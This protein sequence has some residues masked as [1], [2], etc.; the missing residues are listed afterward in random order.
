MTSVLTI[1]TSGATPF[2]EDAFTVRAGRTA[3]DF[4][5]GEGVLTIADTTPPEVTV[6]GEDPATVE[7]S[8]GYSDPGATA[9]DACA[10]D[11]T[12]SIVVTGSVDAGTPGSYEL[13]YEATDA[14]GNTGSAVR[15]VEVV[16]T[17][18]PEV[19]CPLSTSAIADDNCQAPIPDVLTG[20]TAEDECSSFDSLTLSQDPPTGTPVDLGSH[21]ITVTVTDA[22]GNSSTCT[23]GFTVLNPAPVATITG[24]PSG[25]IYPVN[26]PVPLTGSFTDNAGSHVAIWKL[27]MTTISGTVTEANGSG[28]ISDNHTFTEAGVYKIEL[29]VTDGCSPAG[30]DTV[31]TVNDLDD[32]YVVIYDPD[33]GFVTG[34]GW[35]Q[36]PP[37]AY[38]RNPS[39]VGKANFGFVSK[40]K[41]GAT[42]PTG[43]TEFQFRVAGMNF[44]S[45]EYQ[46][47]VVSGSK[48]QYKG[49]GSIN[50]LGSFGFM[51][52]AIDGDL[53][54]SGDSDRFRMKIW[55]QN[56][57]DLVYDNQNG[58]A[59]DSE[60]TTNLEGGSIVIHTGGNKKTTPGDVALEMVPLGAP[61]KVYALHQN[62]PNPF[63]FS[64]Q[65][66]FDLPERSNVTVRVYDIRGRLVSSLIDGEREAGSYQAEWNGRGSQGESLASGV[67]L[68]QFRAISLESHKAQNDTKRMIYLK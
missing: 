54:Q 16:D 45:N 36:S 55:D 1:S 5:T 53:S 24:P 18:P 63:A 40:Y 37:G 9:W 49:I 19:S 31:D 65:V 42:K 35:I 26:T 41:K 12:G 25:S 4:A 28:T 27:D 44:H 2:G 64:T 14:E 43:E 51:L 50:G 7:C 17:T 38:P 56:T 10:G 58:V 21:T 46:W 29:I 59:D 48:A 20:T 62:Y 15:V 6:L 3:M 33:A 39:L 8:S 57:E 68:F 30:S 11:L 60:P 67:Y 13:L 61:P 47:L 66:R 52:T 23:S 22:S 32:A 34:G